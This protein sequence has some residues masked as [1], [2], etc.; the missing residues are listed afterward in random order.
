V[1]LLL[2]APN[3]TLQTTQ[4]LLTAMSGMQVESLTCPV[5]AREVLS[6]IASDKY[7]G[8]HFAGDSSAGVLQLTDGPLAVELLTSALNGLHCLRFVILNSCDSLA[9]AVDIYM[10]STTPR[11]IGWPHQV[12]D[13]AAQ[14]WAV[15]FY[16]SYRLSQNLNDALH[17]ANEMLAR[18]YPDSEEP[19]L[20]NG[21]LATLHARVDDLELLLKTRS[22][23]F[24]PTWLVLAVVVL[25][26]LLLC[27]LLLAL[28]IT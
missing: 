16:R 2:I 1:N 7:D 25:C 21:R 3:A 12:S 24:V 11:V 6:Q 5:T 17:S 9:S 19:R 15:T 20:L 27:A 22:R 23:M 14:A 8:I 4:E 10:Q 13:A 28:G 18:F 26:G